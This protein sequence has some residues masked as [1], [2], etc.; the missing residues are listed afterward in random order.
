MSPKRLSGEGEIRATVAH[1]RGA[2]LGHGMDDEAVDEFLTEQGVGVLSLAADDEPYGLPISFGYDGER[3]YF[4]FAG[5]STEGRKVRFAEA[6]SE[7]SFLAFDV[8][9]EAEWRSAVVR[10]PL[11]RI[12]YDGWEAAREAMLDNAYRPDLLVDVDVAS[13]P[14]VWAL[15]VAERSGRRM[16]PGD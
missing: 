1:E 4:L 9:G 8:A 5:H 3:C 11:E 15:D 7:A 13:D 10:G 12:D 14:R 6:A 16:P 2:L